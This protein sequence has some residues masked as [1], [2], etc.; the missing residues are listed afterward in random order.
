MQK[1]SVCIKIQV[2]LVPAL[3]LSVAAQ[4]FI[5]PLELTV[6]EAADADIQALEP[7]VLDASETDPPLTLETLVI[8]TT[9]DDA[10]PVFSL[11]EFSPGSVS[12]LSGEALKRQ[13]AATLGETLGWQ[14]GVSS[15]Y[16]G[17][18]SSQPVIRGLEG[19]RVRMLRDDLG[20]LDIADISPDH[21][22]ALDPLLLESVEIHRGPAALLYGNSSIGGA[23]NARTRVLAR[24]YSEPRITGA[25][26][27]RF[28]TATDGTASSAWFTL[29]EKELHLSLTGSWREDG[30]V[31]IPG[32]ARTAD[33]QRLEQGA[34]V[35]DP[36]A[37]SPVPVPNPSGTLPNTASDV[38]TLS[39]G[40]SWVPEDNRGY[41]GAAWSHYDALYGLPYLYAGDPTDF[42]G[43][44]SIEARQ[45]RLDLQAGLEL[46]RFGFTRI[47]ARLAYAAYR[48]DEHFSGVGKDLGRKVV[49]TAIEKDALES[50]VD[51]RHE[52]LDGRLSGVFGVQTLHEGLTTFRLV[53]PSF[54]VRT[55]FDTEN[56]GFFLLER[57]EDG[58]WSLQLGSRADFQTLRDDSLAEFG[59]L[60]RESGES[61]SHA[62][63]G[64]WT[65]DTV[66]GLDRLKLT[67]TLSATE[68]LPTAAER[69]AFW[70]NA[71]V[72]R[73]LIGGDLD[74]TPLG[75][76]E[77]TGI[78]LG[79]AL[80]RD[81]I[82]FR[83]NVYHYDF[84]NFIFL[85]E[86]PQLTGG[87]GRAIQ[88]IGREA[89]FTGFESELDW[90]LYTGET[91]QLDLSL[92]TDYVRG[93][94]ETDDEPLPRMPPFRI[95][96]R[97]E[98]TRGNTTAGLEIRYAA[99]Q[100]RVKPA[101][102]AELPTDAYTLVNADLAHTFTLPR[103]GDLT[104]FLRAL[105]LLDEDARIS[106]SFRK[107]VAPL[108]GRGL[109]MGLRHEF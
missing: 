54:R 25:V 9:S 105:N 65:C 31:S 74:G 52:A 92:M 34:L 80:S 96:T 64:G 75:N 48:H 16:F 28:D 2:A 100:D 33:Y 51:L 30:D 91:D 40:L 72:G 43:V 17:P 46:D 88:Y 95:G 29:R 63:T 32:R 12:I 39:L 73:F 69:W 22:V 90:H 55:N 76:E 44:S 53:P 62:L 109:V 101:P 79:V 8:E 18:A 87:F 56:L 57:Y 5:E 59:I 66:P 104:V 3:F 21:G 35:Y 98:W 42:Y 108:P 77:S 6:D 10:P 86:A 15:T 14:P 102:R 60:T 4:D 27:Q 106:T 47:D 70:S 37:G 36:S 13:A 82:D 61:F 103:G 50:R 83:L 58:P 67:G 97:L 23:V 19:V 94:N 68:R 71:G 11:A 99:A 85:Q 1:Q 78:E 93:H 89:T 24:E 41:L 26:E 84:E 49:D 81:P 107:D 38:A 45:D 20:T 7:L